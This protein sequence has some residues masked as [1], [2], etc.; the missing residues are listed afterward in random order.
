MIRDKY[1]MSVEQQEKIRSNNNVRSNIKI[2]WKVA[3]E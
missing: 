3:G 1:A 2:I